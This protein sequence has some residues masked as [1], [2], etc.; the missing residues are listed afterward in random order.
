MSNGYVERVGFG[1]A[2]DGGVFDGST[3]LGLTPQKVIT[4]SHPAGIACNIACRVIN[5]NASAILAFRVVPRGAT[6]PVYDTTF[7][8]SG[9]GWVLPGQQFRIIIPSTVDLYVVASAISSSFAVESDIY[10]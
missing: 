10:V 7:S 5:P 1:V 3:T 6:A 8:A 2:I 4:A 9:G